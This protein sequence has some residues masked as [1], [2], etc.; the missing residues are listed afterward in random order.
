MPD[1]TTADEPSI[2]SAWDVSY[3]EN[4]GGKK[5]KGKKSRR[6]S[7]SDVDVSLVQGQHR[8]TSTYC[9]CIII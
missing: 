3:I 6:N 4:E 8:V 1:S 7:V 9:G 2:S 5:K